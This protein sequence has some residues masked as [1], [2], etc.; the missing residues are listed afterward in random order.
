MDQIEEFCDTYEPEVSVVVVE[1]FIVFHKRAQKMA[2]S[3]MPASQVIGM[4]RVFARKKKARLIMQ[5]A[6]KKDQGANLTQIFEP[7]DHSQSHWVSAYNHGFW[8]LHNLGLVQSELEKERLN[9]KV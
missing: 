3:R 5:E 1:D 7:A 4:L 9:G 6:G 2:G 8:F